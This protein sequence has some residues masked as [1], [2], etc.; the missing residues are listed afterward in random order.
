MNLGRRPVR[1]LAGP[2]VDERRCA[3]VELHAGVIG[4]TAIGR[5]PLAQGQG[6]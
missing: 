6:F 3:V 2:S 1:P 4:G 5:H